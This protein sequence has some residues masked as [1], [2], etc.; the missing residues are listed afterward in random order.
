M[1]KFIV[2]SGGVE[3]ISVTHQYVLNNKLYFENEKVDI[4]LP[5]T[6]YPEL[7]VEQYR[8][9]LT[10]GD[11]ETFKVSIRSKDLHKANQLMTV[12][13]DASLDKLAGHD[14]KVRTENRWGTPSTGWDHSISFVYDRHHIYEGINSTYPD[15]TSVARTDTMHGNVVWWQSDFETYSATSYSEMSMH[16]EPVDKILKRL[17]G[18]NFAGT[19]PLEE[20]VVTAYGRSLAGSVAGIVVRGN[21]VGSLSGFSSSLIIID[22]IIYEGDISKIDLTSVTD[23]IVLR[24]ADAT[25]LYGSRASNGVVLMSTKGPV[26]WP[27]TPPEP[28]VIRKNFSETAFFFPKILADKQGVFSINFTLPESVTEWKWK[29]LAHDKHA[30]FAYAERTIISQLPMMVQPEM[31]GYLYQGDQLVLKSRISNLDSMLISGTIKCIV[32]DMVTGDDITGQL[33]AGS[34]QAFSVKAMS[35][36]IAAFRLS[37]PD[38]MIHPLRVR[39]V[40]TGNNVSDGEE[41]IVPILAKKMLV[42]KSIPLSL[43]NG[44]PPSLPADA[45]PYGISAYVH[46]KPYESLLHA[47]PYLANYPFDCSE[48]T[49]NKILAHA[50][51]A[52]LMRKD[53]ALQRGFET[54]GNRP[55]SDIL[56]VDSLAEGRGESM[57][58]LQIEFAGDQHQ[59]ALFNLLDTLAGNQKIRDYVNVINDNQLPGGGFS[60]FKGGDADP[61]ISIYLLAGLGKAKRDSLLF[62]ADLNSSSVVPGKIV[63]ALIRYADALLIDREAGVDK[64]SALYARSYWLKEYPFSLSLKDIADSLAGKW[65]HNIQGFP[66]GETAM[67]ISTIL[68]MSPKESLLYKEA[69]KELE[70]L[71]QQSISDVDG[72]RWKALSDE[73]D[74]SVKEEEWMVKIAEAFGE[75]EG[76][77]ETVNGLIKWL[78]ASKQDHHWSTT[79][80]T[81]DAV[82]LLSRNNEIHRIPAV[83]AN[84]D[85]GLFNLSVSDDL[86]NGRQYA[87]FNLYGKAFPSNIRVSSN[88]PQELKGALSYYFF[89]TEPPVIENGPS[90]KKSIFRY[91]NTSN[92]WEAMTDSS[93]FNIGD[94]VK[95]ELTIETKRR[96]QYVF[97]DD[98]RAAAF[99]PADPLSGYQYG[100]RLYYYRSV[101]DEGFRF[102]LNEIPAGRSSV[103]YE[104]MVTREGLFSNG[105][106]VLQCMYSPD[107]KAYTGN[108]KV[109]VKAE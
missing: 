29:M 97:I 70:S 11:K 51:A 38:T 23:G 98:K 17:P 100:D 84:V 39:I 99:E 13:Y 104:M 80:S 47:L 41:H 79:K 35:N 67:I 12:L 92:S 91:N 20:V 107:V 19:Q 94:K 68:R 85:G 50:V 108:V 66:I 65:L 25:G 44:T 34:E 57:P 89:T 73:D 5:E 45:Q 95:V 7:V 105:M 10:P 69:M 63:T 42:T 14:W 88:Q 87:F 36:D 6:Q 90:L 101:A 4:A 48:Q 43:A 60:W 83:T 18:L 2:P 52:K 82:S 49:F 33:V 15:Y 26:A 9:K 78:L 56:P 93:V 74:L 64:L 59:R 46:P 27:V 24:G 109:N 72:V 96:L 75:S 53:S 1:L 103:N 40:A 32:E 21:A 106:A 28:P 71:R 8:T 22:G 62:I 58:W 102:F 54:Y 55:L 76:N 16:G 61:Y 37:I 86:L 81:G 31:P 30:R 3:Q 77:K